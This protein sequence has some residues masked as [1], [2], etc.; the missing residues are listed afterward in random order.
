MSYIECFV[1]IPEA[2]DVERSIDK[3]KMILIS[4]NPA[5]Y[6]TDGIKAIQVK[7]S[8]YW[9]HGVVPEFTNDSLFR[10]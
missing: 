6:L 7:V 9:Q 2:S 4:G 5:I 8:G 3:P 10:V 1:G